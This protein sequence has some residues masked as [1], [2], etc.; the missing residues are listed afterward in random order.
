M[1]QQTKPLILKTIEEKYGSVNNFVEK[2]KAKLPIS[3]THIYQLLGYKT[4]NPGILTLSR[5]ADLL[6]LPLSEVI[7]D[8]TINLYKVKAKGEQDETNTQEGH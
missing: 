5:L 7:K 8:Y 4:A 2:E 6:E 1:E 3:R